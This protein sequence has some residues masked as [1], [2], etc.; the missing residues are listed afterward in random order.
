[1]ADKKPLK[2]NAGSLSEFGATDTVGIVNGGTGNS[3]GAGL[4]TKYVA[5]LANCSNSNTETTIYTITIPA[6]TWADGEAV[7]VFLIALHKQNSGGAL[8][9]IQKLYLNSTAYTSMSSVSITN[10]ATEG[11]TDRGYSLRRIG[12]DVYL[13]LSGGFGGGGGVNINTALFTA[14]QFATT[15]GNVYSAV[16]FTSN[17]TIS[18]TMQ[19]ATANANAYFN[20]FIGLAFKI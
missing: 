13:R 6:N 11:R 10:S 4:V 15:S 19:W 3:T 14:D 12:S 5:T 1:M 17:I 8:T 20:P 7:T 2:N 16:D 18:I 9:V